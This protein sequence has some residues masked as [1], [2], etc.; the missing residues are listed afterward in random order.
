MKR[1]EAEAVLNRFFEECGNAVPSQSEVEPVLDRVWERLEWK[2][3]EFV[4]ARYLLLRPAL[5]VSRGRRESCWP[6]YC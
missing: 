3:D 1:Q 2:A 6:Q 5:F 4:G